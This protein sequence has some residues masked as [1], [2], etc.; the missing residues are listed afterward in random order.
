MVPKKQNHPSFG[1]I[2]VSNWNKL[3][4][5]SFKNFPCWKTSFV[6]KDGLHMKKFAVSIFLTKNPKQTFLVLFLKK[7]Q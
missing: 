5:F 1:I 2:P 4:G 7:S 3:S 6:Q